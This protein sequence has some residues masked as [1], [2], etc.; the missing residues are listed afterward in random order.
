MQQPITPRL[1]EILGTADRGAETRLYGDGPAG[2]LPLTA[3]MLREEPSGNLFGLTQNVGM[4]WDPQ[5]A[6][7]SEFVIV[8]TQ[9]GLRAEDGSPIALGYHTG[10]WEIGLLV[11]RA[12]ETIRERGGVPFSVTCS[13]PCDGRTQ[14]TTG[15]FDSLPYRNDAAIVMR[16]LISSLPTCRGVMGVAT[17]D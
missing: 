6:H 2:R 11:R 5:A 9:G 12:A 14:G 17:C 4:G 13:D 3:E 7:G 15:M 8:S 1:D 10:H 16:R